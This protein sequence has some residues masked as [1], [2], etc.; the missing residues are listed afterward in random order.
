MLSDVSK[1]PPNPYM[2]LKSL[3]KLVVWFVW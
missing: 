3:N 2:K 1:N